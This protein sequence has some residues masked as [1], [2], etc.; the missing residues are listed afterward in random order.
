[1]ADISFDGEKRLHFFLDEKVVND[2]IENFE[3]L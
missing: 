2:T 1:M 3:W